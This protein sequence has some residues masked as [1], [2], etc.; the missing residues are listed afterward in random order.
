M[1]WFLDRFGWKDDAAAWTRSLLVLLW[2][3][4]LVAVI[5][6]I[7]VVWVELMGFLDADAFIYLAVGRGILNGFTPYVDLFETKPPGI[8]LLSA[9][10]L[11]LGG[12][13][14][15]KIV[16]ALALLAISG[17]IGF[18]TYRILQPI[19]AASKRMLFLFAILAGL[20]LA[21]FTA[22]FSG[23]LQVESFGAAFTMLY[24]AR[25]AL[26]PD[27]WDNRRILLGSI[28]LGLAIFFKEPFILSAL[29]GSLLLATSF[30]SL[31]TV[32]FL[33]A[34]LAGIGFLLFLLFT[35]WLN[36]YLVYLRYMLIQGTNLYS[37]PILLRGFF[38]D[39]ILSNA[40]LFSPFFA[41]FLVAIVGMTLLLLWRRKQ[42]LQRVGHIVR[43][44]VVLYLAILAVGTGGDFFSHHF[45]FAVPVYGALT[46]FI[47]RES[48]KR[49]NDDLIRFPMMLLIAITIATAF[50]HARENPI[51][52]VRAWKF[53]EQ[54]LKRTAA[55]IDL[56]LDRC[57]IDQYLH[58][59]NKGSG[60][61]GHTKHSPLGPLFLNYSR[62]LTRE[63]SPFREAMLEELTNAEIVALKTY[64][65]SG[66]TEDGWSYI[67]S[68]FIRDVPPCA[69][70]FTQPAPY[71]L[72]FRREK[73]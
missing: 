59:V 66:M 23:G 34:C 41:L 51:A 4:I 7:G 54:R 22:M 40:W 67:Q 3:G 44:L 46:L 53:E 2:I 16:Q 71:R 17:S 9:L 28:P 73:E 11:K 55:A 31:L 18:A 24:L 6:L 65:D 39:R 19:K 47:V 8:F 45:V 14:I 42:T 62:L 68:K 36:P 5:E 61:I 20:L 60:P 72:V 15:A 56:V 50:F 52:K 43:I 69:E 70:P 1:H 33:P 25:V 38:A 64:D 32:F 30:A 57:G 12:T 27:S 58:L 35:G 48:H 13:L 26:H 63:H 29:A 10:S 21:L 49:M 37:G